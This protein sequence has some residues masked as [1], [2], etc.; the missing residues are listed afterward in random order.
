[1]AEEKHRNA[2]TDRLMRAVLTLETVDEAYAFFEDLLTIPEFHSL[3]QRLEVAEKLV[4]KR[5]YQ[6]IGQMTGVSTATISRVNRALC[7]GNKGYMTVLKRMNE[8][9]PNQQEEED[10]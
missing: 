8:G 7:W 5:T 9:N 3:S 6:E 2:Q 4:Q 10:L 1:M